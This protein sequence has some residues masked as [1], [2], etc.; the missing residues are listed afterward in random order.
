VAVSRRNELVLT[1]FLST[2]AVLVGAIAFETKFVQS[3]VTANL[4][5]VAVGVGL[6]FLAGA[7]LYRGR[8]R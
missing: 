7:I 5:A 8:R 2:F 4:I 3:T 1:I 6:G